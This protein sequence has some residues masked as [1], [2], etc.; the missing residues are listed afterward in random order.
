MSEDV[1][2]FDDLDLTALRQRRSYKWRAFDAGV[3]PTFVAEMDYPLAQPLRAALEEFARLGDT[4]YAWPSEDLNRALVDF[5][6]ERWGWA[7]PVDSVWLVPD[8]MVGVLEMLRVL[9]RPGDGVTVNPPVYPPF[10][11]HIAEAGCT[12]VEAPLHRDDD[13][14]YHLDLDAV[15]RAF[16]SGARVYLL[17]NPQNPTGTV[18]TREQ[19]EQV[20]ALARRYD[21]YV[22]SDEI[23]GPLTLPGA[24]HTPYLSVSDAAA[25][26]GFALVSASKAWNIPGLKCAQ[27]IATSERMQAHARRLPEHVLYRTGIAGI[28]ATIAAYRDGG[29]WLDQLHSVLDRNRTLMAD[30]VLE[31]L[32]D[33]NY[34]PPRATY[35]AWLDCTALHIDGDLGDFF[36]EHGGVAVLDGHA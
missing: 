22:I 23:H 34:V 35:L 31:L 18:H 4:G 27:L 14:V 30:L 10:Y 28:H 1:A 2:G 11:E 25:E 12:A 15:E 19:L 5:S 32:P 8:V 24:T 13:G 33:V 16:A 3:L 21:A 7:P 6:D 9:L 29:P 17:C 20:A 36:R 26:R